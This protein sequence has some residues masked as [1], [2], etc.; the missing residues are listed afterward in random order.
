MG[1]IRLVGLDLDG[2]LLDEKKA[3]SAPTM[4]ALEEAARQGV[5][6]VPGD[7]TAPFG[8]SEAG[9]NPSLCALHHL[10]QWRLHP[11]RKK[12]EPSCGNA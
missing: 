1:K 12:T 11:G 7:G 2:T 10:L 3:I 9:A 4:E 5:Y 8:H 6:L